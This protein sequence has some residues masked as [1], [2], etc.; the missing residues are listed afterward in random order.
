ME[1]I[2]VTWFRMSGLVIA[3][4]LGIGNTSVAVEVGHKLL[5]KCWTVHYHACGVQD[6]SSEI[7]MLLKTIV[8]FSELE[9]ILEADE[10]EIIPKTL[11][12]F[13][14]AALDEVHCLQLLFV[15]R[16]AIDL[17]EDS[18]F[19]L[20]LEPLKS[21][22]AVHL[23]Q[24]VSPTSSNADL[25]VIVKGWWMQSTRYH[26]SPSLNS[27][28]NIRN[29]I[30]HMMSSS[31]NF[32]KK[33]SHSVVKRHFLKETETLLNGQSMRLAQNESLKRFSLAL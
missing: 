3:G 24:S 25:E 11:Q 9:N 19:S 17:K 18:A 1:E 13:V 31:D 12:R 2:I 20:K 32:W 8:R 5:S 6:P 15:S 14:D 33:L 30:V 22:V 26:D 23:L 28:R 7:E 29:D 16:K 10:P 27:K 4:P 21:A